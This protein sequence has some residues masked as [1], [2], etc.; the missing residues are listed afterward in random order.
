MYFIVFFCD[1]KV[2]RVIPYKW[3]R[4][5]NYENLINNGMNR[6]KMF[7]AFYTQDQNAFE[8]N[9]VPKMSYIPNPNA[10]GEIFPNA[11]WYS[12]KIRKFK[13]IE[14]I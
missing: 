3:I 9:G 12:C 4:G 13:G 8:A 5:I 7:R 11:G 10:Q 2:H 6:N 1:P 14:I